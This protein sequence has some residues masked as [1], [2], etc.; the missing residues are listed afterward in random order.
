MTP[1]MYQQTPAVTPRE[2]LKTLSVAADPSGDPYHGS[3]SPDSP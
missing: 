2:A 1:V 3:R